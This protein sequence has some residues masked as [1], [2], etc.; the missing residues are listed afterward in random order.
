[1]AH[2]RLPDYP[3]MRTVARFELLP[4]AELPGSSLKFSPEGRCV[5]LGQ[6][7][8]RSIVNCYRAF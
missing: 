8:G 1:V 2:L 3:A 6:K 4:A 7:I 5:V